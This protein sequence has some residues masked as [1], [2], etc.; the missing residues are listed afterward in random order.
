MRARV[1]ARLCAALLCASGAAGSVPA[2]ADTP[3]DCRVAESQLENS[4]PLPQVEAAIARKRLD[5]LIVGAGSSHLPGAKGAAQSY[6]ARLQNALSE[7]LPG[8]AVKVAT[9]VKSGRTA[10]DMLPGLKAAVAAGKPA[11]L[12][13]QTG[14]VDALRNVEPEEFSAVLVKGVRAAKQAGADA[15]L[16][17][18]QYSPRTESLIALG[19]YV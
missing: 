9:D 1:A 13:W 19:N 10:R 3:A 6:P 15:V 4:F 7:K 16:M 17:N 2:R 8:V 11:L 12:V 14:T 5:V 18:M